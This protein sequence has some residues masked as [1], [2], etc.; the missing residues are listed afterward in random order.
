VG[1]KDGP[2]S[3]RGEGDWQWSWGRDHGGNNDPFCP[4]AGESEKGCLYPPYQM[5]LNSCPMTCPQPIQQR[6]DKNGNPEFHRNGGVVAAWDLK[7]TCL[8][9]NLTQQQQCSHLLCMGA[10]VA[11]QGGRPSQENWGQTQ[12]K[13]DCEVDRNNDCSCGESTREACIAGVLRLREE[14]CKQQCTQQWCDYMCVLEKKREYAGIFL[15]DNNENAFRTE[16]CKANGTTCVAVCRNDQRRAQVEKPCGQD[17]VWDHELQPSRRRVAM[18]GRYMIINDR[19]C[20][21]GPTSGTDFDSSRGEQGSA[22]SEWD[23]AEEICT[24]G[25]FGQNE[26]SPYRPE[27]CGA[28]PLNN[29]MIALTMTTLFVSCFL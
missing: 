19:L 20:G 22:R 18:G 15:N 9:R 14:Q 6:L 1:L 13:R 23:I 16:S 21:D 10:I 12:R 27:I 2:N 17:D 7:W 24:Q 28:P 25:Q 8:I 29:V 11:M 5:E 26:W 3:I 4:K